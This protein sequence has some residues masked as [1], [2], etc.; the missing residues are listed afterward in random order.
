MEDALNFFLDNKRVHESLEA[1]DEA[2]DYIFMLDE[3]DLKILTEEW[4]RRDDHWRS[5][6]SYLIGNL[7]IE[8]VQPLILKG[9]KDTSPDVVQ[10]TLLTLHQSITETEKTD[11]GI[12]EDIK[13]AAFTAI[14]KAGINYPEIAEL[15]TL[16]NKP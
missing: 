11:V 15:R 3:E 1:P 10:E 13:L 9:L 16:L 12:P 2:I 4:D 7:E 14:E 8:D 6:V 5:A